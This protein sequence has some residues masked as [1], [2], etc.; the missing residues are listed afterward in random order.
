AEPH[1]R[2]R[3]FCSPHHQDSALHPII[4]HMERAA[5]FARDE[6]PGEKLAKL[7]A[8]LAPAAPTEV[9]TALV[10]E[11]LSLPNAAAHLNLSPQRKREMLFESLLYPVEVIAR[12]APVL[13]VFEDV[14][15]IDPTSR[16]LLDHVISRAARMQVLLIVTFRPE[17][18]PPWS[19]QPHVTLLAL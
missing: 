5:G 17:F 11:L 19:G 6:A 1:T 9:A 16:E 8:L 12:Q 3:Y 7:R 10:A 2:L 4:V 18:Q 15:W 14:H 13:M